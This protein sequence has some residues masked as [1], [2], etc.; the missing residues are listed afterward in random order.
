MAHIHTHHFRAMGSGIFIWLE[1]AD[2]KRARRLLREAEA[3][4]S[5][6]E[7]QLSRFRPTSELSQLNNRQEQWVPVSIGLWRAAK[8]AL[9][10][11][12][13]TSGLFDPTLWQAMHANG[14]DQSF[15]TGQAK[16]APLGRTTPG[17]FR[18]VGLDP[19]GRALWLPTGVRLDL[20]GMGKGFTAQHVVDFL[21]PWGPCLV[22]AGGDLTAGQAPAQR[23]GWPV[24]VAAPS[25]G[26][27]S[28]TEQYRLE[29][30]QQSLATSAVD[31]RQW[32]VG[33]AIVRH[34]ID[35]RTGRSTRSDILSASVIHPD[36]ATAEAWATAALVCDVDPSFQRLD[37]NQIAAS[38]HSQTGDLYLTTA[39]EPLIQ[40][41]PAYLG[42]VRRPLEASGTAA[43]AYPASAT[44]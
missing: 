8:A 31:Y 12:A 24:A 2:P 6:A 33:K 27:G 42:S 23:N 28:E 19:A 18:K 39:L 21:S 7:Q 16:T 10:L 36:A 17:K 26:S 40:I 11:A 29:L 43:A 20:G 30:R 41:D 4:F 32:R 44:G 35:P 9:N 38:L 25:C 5:R 22:A 1:L 13:A 37:A 14:Y 3:M 15:R 34:I